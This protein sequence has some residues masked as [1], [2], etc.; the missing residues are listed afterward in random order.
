MFRKKIKC[1]PKDDVQ[2]QNYYR[3]NELNANDW[4]STKNSDILI[5]SLVQMFQGKEQL[6]FSAFQR[7]LTENGLKLDDAVKTINYR[8]KLRDGIVGEKD[9]DE[10]KKLF[11]DKKERYG[12]IELDLE[13]YDK[14]KS[15]GLPTPFTSAERAQMETERKEIGDWL[16]A[17]K[18]AAPNHE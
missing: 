15:K 9:L 17:N 16:Q 11:I 13:F 5:K 10:T 6:S 12:E 3:I 8:D 18:W 4:T 14:K 2:V 7:I 1:L